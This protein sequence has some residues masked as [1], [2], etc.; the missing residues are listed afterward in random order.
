MPILRGKPTRDPLPWALFVATLTAFIGTTVFLVL[1]SRSE[2]DRAHAE[3]AEKT[4]A[5]A[6]ATQAE[7]SLS[8]EKL[9]SAQLGEQVRALTGERD[10]LSEKLRAATVASAKATV[11]TPVKAVKKPVA[12]KPVAKKPVKKRK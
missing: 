10:A 5:E 2:T 11:K 1:R 8:G 3:Y 4:A 9:K 6:R 7:E 12:K